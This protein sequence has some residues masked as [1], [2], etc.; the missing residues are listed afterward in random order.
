MYENYVKEIE[1]ASQIYYYPYKDGELKK[2]FALRFDDGDYSQS[3]G[4]VDLVDGSDEIIPTF[5]YFNEKREKIKSEPTLVEAENGTKNISISWGDN[6]LMGALSLPGRTYNEEGPTNYH[7]YW[8]YRGRGKVTVEYTN[9]EG[10]LHR[11]KGPAYIEGTLDFKLTSRLFYTNGKPDPLKHFKA[12]PAMREVVRSFKQSTDK[13]MR[14]YINMLKSYIKMLKDAGE[15]LEAKLNENNI[16]KLEALMK[17]KPRG[18]RPNKTRRQATARTRA[19]T[20]KSKRKSSNSYSSK[21]RSKS[22]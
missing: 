20:R 4:L 12:N 21:R 2:I 3:S 10:E 22:R 6:A 18:R 19:S 9:S 7:Y 5:I 8:D 15:T 14:G 17:V 11:D 13:G 16:K 1:S